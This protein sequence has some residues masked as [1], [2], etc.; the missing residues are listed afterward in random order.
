MER[1]YHTIGRVVGYH[2]CDLDVARRL[3]THELDIA[4]SEN[5]YD[6]LGRGAYFW[7]DSPQRGIECAIEKSKRNEIESPCVVGAFMHLGMH[8]PRRFRRNG[9]YRGRLRA[10]EGAA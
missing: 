5:D 3:L 4:P 8:E 2:G 1:S 6:W 7:V 9:R 10:F